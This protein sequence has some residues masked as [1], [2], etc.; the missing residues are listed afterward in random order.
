[1]LSKNDLTLPA[2]IYAQKYENYKMFFNKKRYDLK[3]KIKN[4]IFLLLILT[5][6]ASLLYSGVLIF[7]FKNQ[8]SYTILAN[9]GYLQ[10]SHKLI[11]DGL[12]AFAS[13]VLATISYPW[14]VHIDNARTLFRNSAF[15]FGL[16]AIFVPVWIYAGL[17]GA[18]LF[19]YDQDGSLGIISLM[20]YNGML[21]SARQSNYLNDLMIFYNAFAF[22]I[23]GAIGLIVSVV[24]Y[25]YNNSFT[26]DYCR[27]VLEP[28]GALQY[29]Y[30]ENFNIYANKASQDAEI[31]R[32]QK[33]AENIQK[34]KFEN[35][36]MNNGTPVAP[37]NNSNISYPLQQAWQQQPAQAI[38]GSAQEYV[39]NRLW[40]GQN[41]QNAPKQDDPNTNQTQPALNVVAPNKQ[42]N[43]HPTDTNITININISKDDGKDVTYTVHKN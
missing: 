7:A 23:I 19:S 13:A 35:W 42:D 6:F 40:N 29:T 20:H 11:I 26:K 36:G 15:Y 1:M 41:G 21:L 28:N 10:I 3:G 12:V 33:S 5:F 22:G 9:G 24:M 39:R 17:F 34:M 30:Y 16:I 14:S 32:Q 31:A 25:F 2:N 8:V 43:A 27:F 37:N 4:T 38:N 18:L